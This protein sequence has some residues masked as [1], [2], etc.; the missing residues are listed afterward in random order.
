MGDLIDK[1]IPI[2]GER[3]I[4]IKEAAALLQVSYGTVY[5]HKEALGFV[6]CRSFSGHTRQTEPI[7]KQTPL[8]GCFRMDIAASPC[9][10]CAGR[11][12][13]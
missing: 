12:L 10:V 3:A 11:R 8:L 5:T 6:V 7:W 13:L 1:G 4:G 2:A 9:S